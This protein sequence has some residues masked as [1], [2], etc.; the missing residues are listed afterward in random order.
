MQL[1]GK[2]SVKDSLACFLADPI[3]KDGTYPA[4][5]L[6]VFGPGIPGSGWGLVPNAADQSLSLAGVFC[7]EFIPKANKAKV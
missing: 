5:L 1:W 3:V 6:P 7:F 4:G 2:D